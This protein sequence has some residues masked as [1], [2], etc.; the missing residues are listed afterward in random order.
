MTAYER[1]AASIRRR[2][3]AS[4]NLN[5]VTHDEQEIS[6]L[7]PFELSVVSLVSRSFLFHFSPRI[8][9]IIVIVIQPW[10]DLIHVLRGGT[11]ILCALSMCC[12]SLPFWVYLAGH[13]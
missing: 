5:L 1:D 7:S 11:K 6:R 3:I 4:L 13:R 10:A 9:V 12:L 8:I 2:F